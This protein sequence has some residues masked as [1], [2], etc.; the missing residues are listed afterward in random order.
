MRRNGACLRGPAT[1]RFPQCDASCRRN[2][3]CRRTSRSDR[4]RSSQRDLALIEQAR[5]VFECHVLDVGI[6]ISKPTDA[7]LV[8]VRVPPIESRLD[9]QVKLIESPIQR[10][11]QSSPDR[12]LN[13]IERDAE[14]SRVE[15]LVQHYL[16]LAPRW[17]DVKS[18]CAVNGELASAARGSRRV[19]RL[20]SRERVV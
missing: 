13:F 18:R 20:F 3:M 10:H 11:D 15:F 6:A 8:K 4:D 5:A 7:K 14:C 12:R 17:Y 2:R 19:G 16:D 9:R 1:P